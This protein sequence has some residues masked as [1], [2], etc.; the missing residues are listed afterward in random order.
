MLAAGLQLL[1]LAV[2]FIDVAGN[3]RHLFITS[4]VAGALLGSAYLIRY[5]TFLLLPVVLIYLWLRDKAERRTLLIAV[6]LF[7][8]SFGLVASPQLIASATVTGSPLYNEQA[9]NVWFGLYGDFNWTDNW[10]S[11]PTDVTLAKIIRDDPATFLTHWMREFGRF[12]AYDP[13]A[14]AD[15]PLALERK[16]TFWEPLLNHGVW[17]ASAFLLLFDK[18]LTRPQIALLL[19]ALFGPVLATSMAWLFT[20]YLL[21]PLAVQVVLIV[22]AVSQLAERLARTER[23]ATGVSLTLVLAFALLFWSSTTWGVKQQRTREIVRRVQEAQPLLE[24]AGVNQ[25]AQLMTN[26][27]LYQILDRPDHPQYLLFQPLIEKPA[28]VSL[29]IQQLKGLY[30]PEFMLFDWTSHAIRTI[31]VAPYRS[32]LLSAKDQLAP[33]QLTDDYSLY[34]VVPCRADA[35]TVIDVALN[36]ALMLA[37]YRALATHGDEQGLYLFWKLESPMDAAQL[38]SLTLRDK[39]GNV[40]FQTTGHAQQGTYPLDRWRPGEVV[41]DY[42][43][44]SSVEVRPNETYYLTLDLVGSDAAGPSFGSITVSIHFSAPA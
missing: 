39:A 6:A 35:A 23:A 25:P 31:E 33:L 32:A 19:M 15:D 41:T 4:A 24:A 22:L 21:V 40:V 9:R 2:V 42:Y 3:K 18:R 10:G 20:R 26:N 16:V 37:G 11:I 14:Y 12:L 1:A 17:L 29:L 36:P 34:C 43:L 44:L 27:R 8:G 7:A 38:I 28:T 30:Q 13:N 5:T